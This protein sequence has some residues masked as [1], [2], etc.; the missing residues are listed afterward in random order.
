[1]CRNDEGEVIF[2]NTNCC[3]PLNLSLVKQM[4]QPIAA[5]HKLNYVKFEV[6]AMSSS[7][8]NPDLAY[9]LDEFKTVLNSFLCWDFVFVPRHVYYLAHNIRWP[10]FF[11]S[12][13]APLP[14]LLPSWVHLLEDQ[15]WP[16]PLLPSPPPPPPLS[17]L[18]I[19]L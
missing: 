14:S 13:V 17:P 3:L 4:L 11:L 18:C 6:D 16:V 8:S 12:G 15:D 5:H 10:F 7:S 2:S 9:I 19:L 1:M